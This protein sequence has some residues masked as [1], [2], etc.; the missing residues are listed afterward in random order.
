ML[1]EVISSM[2]F[3]DSARNTGPVGGALQ[4]WKA[5][6]TRIGSWSAGCTFCAHLTAGRA[7][8]IRSPNRRGSVMVCRESCWP[9]VTTTAFRTRWH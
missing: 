8:P 7:I 5:R 9:A 4:S 3:I 2:T 6:R 1:T